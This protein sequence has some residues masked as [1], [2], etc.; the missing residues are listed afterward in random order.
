ME[1]FMEE[2]KLRIAEKRG[3]HASVTRTP[4]KLAVSATFT[5]EPVEEYIRW[6]GRQCQLDIDVQFAPYNQ[7]SR[8]LADKTGLIS[9]NLSPG[10]NVLLIRFED[11]LR[12]VESHLTDEEKC[13]KLEKDFQELIRIF[14]NKKKTALNLV[15]IFPVSS[16]LLLS[17]LL[18][19]YL[20]SMNLRWKSILKEMDKD[21]VYEIDFR[22]LKELYNTREV[23][24]TVMDKEGHLP[25][26]HE[27]Y[28][29]MGTAIARQVVAFNHHPFKV[30]VLD[31]DNTLWQGICGENGAWG[32]T[33]DGPYVWLQQ[34]MLQK[35]NEGL[36]LAL[37]SKNNEAD[38]WEVFEKN[39]GML[40]KKD[41]FVAWRINWKTKSENL[42]QLA[43]ELNLGIN[44][45]I[46]IDDSPAECLEV[47]SNCPGVLTL[48]LP[49]DPETIPHFLKH[50]RAFDKAVVTEEDKVRTKMYQADKKRRETR[51][52]A[53]SLKDY[54][55]GLELKISMNEMK[56]SLVNRVSQLTQRTNQ[57]NLS[58][59]RRKEDEILS[60]AKQ[61]GTTCWVVEVSDRFG[62]YGLV[63]VV[64]TEEKSDHLFID[65][66]LLSCR[67]L[68]RGVE[69]AILVGLKKN[70]HANRIKTL[71]ADFY[72]T[73]KNRPVLDFL[74]SKWTKMEKQ[75]QDQYTSFTLPL[76]NIP[77]SIEF[78]E[79]YFRESFKTGLP[80]E[81]GGEAGDPYKTMKHTR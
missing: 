12:D 5:A 55:A 39:P 14:K 27:F 40:L 66:F 21:K 53:M 70:C 67:V 77:G 73:Q 18:A 25:F 78:G 15:G 8:E 61:P 59:I 35:Y 72:P 29:A 63:G 54:L 71:K 36:L 9:T 57:F 1:L 3:L 69:D 60:L 31:C 20:E 24:D 33:V 74:E 26:S 23:F 17:P 52:R 50:V 45:F 22:Q 56:P 41:H 62:D 68:G 79:L 64:I 19:G 32:V 7:A 6:W 34:F 47:I 80:A 49:Q 65:T 75:E 42:N 16:H 81:A 46:F 11:W 76:E 30:I 51:D 44:S 4:V 38:V 28:A 58:T 37:C 43:E 10:I 2:E 48:Q 13:N